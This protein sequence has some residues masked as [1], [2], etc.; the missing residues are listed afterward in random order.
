MEPLL[1]RLYDLYVAP[2]LNSSRKSWYLVTGFTVVTFLC[3]IMVYT[4]LS[5]SE[6]Q[7]H[8]VYVYQENNR[9]YQEVNSMGSMF[10]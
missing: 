9:G 8:T 10:Q 2:G 6:P 1:S 7:Y 3:L 5:R 4:A